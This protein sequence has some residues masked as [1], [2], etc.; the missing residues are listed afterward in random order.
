MYN[1]GVLFRAS[2]AF[3]VLT[4]LVAIA[5]WLI[6]VLTVMATPSINGDTW[7]VQRSA[8]IE[9]KAPV[10]S[11]VVS[12]SAAIHRDPLSRIGEVFSGYPKSAVVEIV[13]QPLNTVST[14][15]NG[16]LVVDDKKTSYTLTSLVPPTKLSGSYLAVCVL[17]PCGTPGTPVTVPVDHMLGKVLGGIGLHGI[18]SVPTYSGTRGTNG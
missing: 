12:S 4:V 8:W 13:A 11:V 1:A 2:I 17:G 14:T 9:G 6:L 10:G 18:D 5:S 7:A 3:L 15:L 16:T